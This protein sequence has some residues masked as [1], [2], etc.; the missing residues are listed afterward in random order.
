MEARVGERE[1]E[2]AEIR[3]SESAGGRRGERV[4][5]QRGKERVFAQG[6]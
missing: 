5:S 2:S 4:G 1:S 6:K 3:G